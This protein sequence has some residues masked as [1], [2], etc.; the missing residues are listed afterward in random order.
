MLI[1]INNYCNFAFL[2]ELHSLR[3]EASE[4]ACSCSV[5]GNN[6][7]TEPIIEL[8][9]PYNVNCDEEG[10]EKCKQLCIALVSALLPFRIV[11]FYFVH[12]INYKCVFYFLNKDTYDFKYKSHY[13]VLLIQIL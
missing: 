3:Q 5:F 7:G 13:N 1:V 6:S 12:N 9:L 8:T 4:G 11:Y 2:K 10:N